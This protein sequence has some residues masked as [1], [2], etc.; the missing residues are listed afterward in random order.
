[1]PICREIRLACLCVLLTLVWA[2]CDNSTSAPKS[3][4]VA[5]TPTTMSLQT[6]ATQQFTATVSNAT[7]TAVTWQVSGVAGGNASVGTISSSGLY[8]AP[9][10]VPTPATVTVAAVS[11]AD[12]T[13]T[14]SA[15]VTVTAPP[16]ITVT[17]TPNAPTVQTG[18]TQQFTATVANTTNTAVAWQVNGIAGGNATIGTISN[19]GLYTA[20]AAVPN[21]AAVTVTAVSAADN[22]KSGSATATVTAPPPITV[23]VSPNA[24]NVVVNATQQ[25]TATVTNT[26]NTAVTWKVN[27]VTGGSSAAG[28]ISNAGLYTAPIS[29]PNPATVTVTAVSVADGTKSGSAAVTVASA[30][31]ITVTV[32][33]NSAN[34]AVNGNQQFTATVTG[35][36]NTAVTWQVD[37]VT[38]GNATVGT[39]SGTGSYTG[40]S[41]VPSP[42]TVTV[43]A[44]STADNTKSGTSNVTVTAA[45]VA[46]F[47]YVSSFP[48]NKIA[49]YS[50]NDTTGLLS[51]TT[52]VSLPSASNPGFLGMHP[53]G[54]FL[55]SLNKGTST[56]SIFAV[57]TTSGALT[58]AG[59]A[60]TSGG[61]FYM[62]FSPNGNYAYVT[63]DAASS[64]LAFS[65]NTTTGGLTAV[66][67]S[68]YAISGGR[69]RGLAISPDNK[70]LYVADRDATPAGIIGFTINQSTGALTKMAAP[71]SGEFLGTL[72]I[73]KAGKYLYA[74]SPDDV[75]V[76]GYSINS[77]TG[78]LTFVA[79]YPAG[80]S[81]TSVWVFDPTG[82]Y[83][84]GGST[85]DNKVFGYKQ[86][87]DGSLTSISGMPVSSATLPNGGGVHPNAKFAY[88]VSTISETTLTSGVI[89]IYSVN[90]TT[91][92][93]SQINSTPAGVNNT[94]GFAITP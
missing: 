44:V 57:N 59:S 79:D 78:A 58:A 43:K 3:V 50:V 54:K 10:S 60:A 2:G 7:N 25:F 36:A 27:G 68:P 77:S 53:S 52:T 88:A 65:V 16:P 38:G 6:G 39:I 4:S 28:T 11:Q 81:D 90:Q 51:P 21:P 73:D 46:R 41:S 82:T 48:D 92:A 64:V 76:S 67:G 37:N 31:V 12:G 5:V 9:A 8:T 32:A 29:V 24:A 62:V 70:Y 34:V 1:M 47:A 45:A 93:F 14:G 33:P 17:V 84:Y 20:P 75:N 22:T 18:A 30:P 61:P 80:T 42:A 83:L 26:S 91:G 19:G 69:V 86:N 87:P 63:C 74:G 49:I 89:T 40:P 23:T 13:K 71:F 72:V 15:T 35:T 85:N 94:I 56:V 66:S 55:Y